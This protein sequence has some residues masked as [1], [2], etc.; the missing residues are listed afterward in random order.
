MH[1][2]SS[3]S[4][5]QAPGYS[6]S[7]SEHSATPAVLISDFFTAPSARCASPFW[8][9]GDFG[10]RA[11]RTQRARHQ[12]VGPQ[13]TRN[14]S[15]QS[16]SSPSRSTPNL[17]A[18]THWLPPPQNRRLRTPRCRSRPLRWPAGRSAAW[19]RWRR[20]PP[21]RSSRQSRSIETGTLPCPK[22]DTS[23]IWHQRDEHVN[24]S[25]R[26]RAC[27]GPVPASGG[28]GR[29]PALVDPPD[30]HDHARR[31]GAPGPDRTLSAGRYQHFLPSSFRGNAL[32][33]RRRLRSAYLAWR[34]GAG[35]QP[36]L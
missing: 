31:E 34:A 13:L 2:R 36:C 7:V 10:R 35:L 33:I 17:M 25:E 18:P 28:S 12:G 6:A 21:A 32:P 15:S 26:D 27:G 11:T 9:E 8:V 29:P 5:L 14:P 1:K 22:R 19:R 3:A 30:S 4:A 16:H 24:A 20:V 23:G